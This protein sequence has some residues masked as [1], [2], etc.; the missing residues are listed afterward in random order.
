WAGVP[1]PSCF[2]VAFSSAAAERRTGG[3]QES[4]GCS[5]RIGP[6][7]ENSATRAVARGPL[8]SYEPPEE[9]RGIGVGNEWSMRVSNGHS[10]RDPWAGCYS[11]SLTRTPRAANPN[12]DV[13]ICGERESKPACRALRRGLPQGR[14]HLRCGVWFRQN[15]RDF[16]DSFRQN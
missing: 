1:S 13:S 4:L 3:A 6:V 8:P 15:R 2:E 10:S 9:R 5:R 12:D 11:T 16:F 7:Q 14:E